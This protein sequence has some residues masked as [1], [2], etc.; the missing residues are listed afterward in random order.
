MP[1]LTRDAQRALHEH[2]VIVVGSGAGG[3]MAAWALA[4]QGVKVLMLEAGRDYDPKSE[5]PMFQE[6]WEAPL[7]AVGTPDKPFNYYDA[8]IGGWDLDGEPYLRGESDFHWF[9][10]RMLGGRT[11]HWGRHS[12]RFGPYDFEPASRDGGGIDWPIAYDEMA[13]WYDRTEKLCGVNGTN[14]GLENHPSSSPGVLQPW[15]GA[16]AAELFVKAGANALGIPVEPARRMILTRDQD[17]RTACFYATPCLRG[18]SIGAAFQSTTSLI[19]LALDTGNLTVLTDAHVAEVTTH[20][21]GRAKGVLFIDRQT[22]NRHEATARAVVLAASSCETARILL[23]SRDGRGLANGSGRVGRNLMDTVGTAAWA[24]FPALGGR[25]RYNE[26][27]TAVGHMYMPWWLY[28]EQ[29][30]GELDFTRGYHIEFNTDM[31]KAPMFNIS[32]AARASGAYGRALRDAAYDHYG[33]YVVFEG[34]GEM[35]ASDDCYM[36]LDGS[37]RDR[38]GLP[39]AK[40][41][42]QWSDQEL[43]QVRHMRRTFQDVTER[44][45]GELLARWDQDPA[46]AINK[47]G[48]IIHEVGTTHMGDD[49]EHSVTDRWSR[50]HEVPNLMIADGGVF[51]SNPH[52]NP[53]LTILALAWRGAERL[54][55]DARARSV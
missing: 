20:A 14:S 48:E 25:P 11:N 40:F 19:P 8:A 45:G 17:I 12:P 51:C 38:F 7:R 44:L 55:G 43:N 3:G 21:D 26:D 2:D 15:V 53:T 41:H 16:R 35:V 50:A 47:P 49:P 36:E 39:V 6:N 52:K 28:Q 54:A 9:R 5:T 46:Q 24:R 31:S 4:R 42:W 32:R 37:L 30:R 34:R 29:A 22:G 23:N 1:P 27:G 13:P 33:S 18:C 10:T